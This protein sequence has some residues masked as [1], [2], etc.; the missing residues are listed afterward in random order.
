MLTFNEEAHAY[1]WN[2]MRVPNVTSIIKPLTD[3]S[4]VPPDVLEAARMQGVAI[5]KMVELYENDDLDTLPNWL[6]PYLD[7]YKRFKRDTSFS[8]LLSE[9]RIYNQQH[10]YAGTPDLI[11]TFYH[12][13]LKREVCALG[14]IKRSFMAGRAIGVQTAAYGQ[15]WNDNKL[16]PRVT[17]RFGLQ[18]RPDGTYRMREFEDRG[19]W[20]M[21]LACLTIHRYHEKEAA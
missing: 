15:S 11:G 7:A 4:F 5:H 20:A 19:D 12:P 6:T 18:L 17:H 8:V 13:K 21:F 16:E 9:Q 2:G 3:Y 1:F 14:D 10:G